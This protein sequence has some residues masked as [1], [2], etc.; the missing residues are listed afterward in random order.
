MAITHIVVVKKMFR[1]SNVFSYNHLYQPE[2]LNEKRYKMD[3]ILLRRIIPSFQYSNIP[4][5]KCEIQ[6]QILENC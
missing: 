6:L 1:Y 5:T 4:R 3:S 2:G